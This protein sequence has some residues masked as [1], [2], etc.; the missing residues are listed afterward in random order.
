ME[1]LKPIEFQKTND[2]ESDKI[3]TIRINQI[4]EKMILK[5]QDNGYGHTEDG[6]DYF[7]NLICSYLNL[8]SWREA[9]KSTFQQES[10]LNGIFFPETAQTT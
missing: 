7:F 3:I 2:P 4:I 1:V 10:S 5:I 6:N 8:F 9:V